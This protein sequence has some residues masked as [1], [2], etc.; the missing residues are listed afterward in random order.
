MVVEILIACTPNRISSREMENHLF[1]LCLV[2]R[3]L[4]AMLHLDLPIGKKFFM[5]VKR[6]RDGR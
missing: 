4:E 6:L 3:E 1:T 5:L 2:L